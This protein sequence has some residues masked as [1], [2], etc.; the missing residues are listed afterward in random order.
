[1]QWPRLKIDPYL[2]RAFLGIAV[3]YDLGVLVVPIH[4]QWAPTGFPRQVIHYDGGDG[5]S[6]KYE[7]INTMY[8]ESWGTRGLIYMI[9]YDG[10][11]Y[12]N[13]WEYSTDSGFT[14]TAYTDTGP[15]NP[16][17]WSHGGDI[18]SDYNPDPNRDY[19]W[20]SHDYG[21]TWVKVHDIEIENWTLGNFV[22]P[23]ASESGNVIVSGCYWF[24]TTLAEYGVAVSYDGGVTWTA[25]YA[26]HEAM[27]GNGI[28][29]YTAINGSGNVMFAATKHELWRSPGTKDFVKVLT[30]T[31][32]HSGAYIA[33][34]RY[35]Y[36]EHIVLIPMITEKDVEWIAISKNDGATWE[37]LPLPAPSLL[38]GDTSGPNLS[39]AGSNVS[40]GALSCQFAYF[41]EWLY[42]ASPVNGLLWRTEDWGETWEA[43]WAPY[44]IDDDDG[45][46]KW[47]TR[48]GAG[49]TDRTLARDGNTIIFQADPVNDSDGAT[50]YLPEL[51]MYSTD[52]GETYKQ[53][54]HSIYYD[55]TVKAGNRGQ[56][57]FVYTD[58]NPRVC[59]DNGKAGWL[60]TH[61]AGADWTWAEL[62]NNVN[63]YAMGVD[64]TFQKILLFVSSYSEWR[65]ELLY[66]TD[67]GASFS[68]IWH[69]TEYTGT[70]CAISGDGSALFFSE[71]GMMKSTDGG[72]TWTEMYYQGGELY[73]LQASSNGLVV[74]GKTGVRIYRYV[75]DDRTS[76][77]TEIDIPLEG[78]FSFAMHMDGNQFVACTEPEQ[79]S[80]GIDGQ[81]NFTLFDPVETNSTRLALFKVYAGHWPETRMS[82]SPSLQG[83]LIATE[84]A[85]YLYSSSGFLTPGLIKAISTALY[86]DTNKRIIGIDRACLKKISG[87]PDD[88]QYLP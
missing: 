88:E 1:M 14:W 87:Q 67:G 15:R 13:P 25:S 63:I 65:R 68:S 72:D 54:P 17:G 47:L 19:F 58:N 34:I 51:L 61:N 33:G 41:N 77:N 56:S 3:D 26:V 16:R 49:K 83:C 29:E 6:V 12:L 22:S 78:T 11:C 80:Y 30:S 46:D 82:S 81:S 44:D 53:F 39:G 28:V 50:F 52:K 5:W 69:S 36:K 23:S 43:I 27:E 45:S 8:N 2:R 48:A 64:S 74:S 32:Y 18:Y 75:I 66:S 86:R 4:S 24:W 9:A 31:T 57:M 84:R 10:S 70:G 71:D 37:S 59:D 76:F 35:L 20:V 60:I 7:T 38:G 21:V 85:G 73:D 40:L 79:V 55:R 62:E 42:L